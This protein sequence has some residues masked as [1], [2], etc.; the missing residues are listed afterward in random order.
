[1]LLDKVVGVVG[2]GYV[3]L[4]LAIEFGSRIQTVAYDINE[5]KVR[6]LQNHIAATDWM[7]SDE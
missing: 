2:L 5:S 7:F 3:G 4:P 6:D 1:M